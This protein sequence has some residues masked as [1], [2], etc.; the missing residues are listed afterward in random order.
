MADRTELMRV[1]RWAVPSAALW[2]ERKEAMMAVW[3]ADS[4]A[5]YWILESDV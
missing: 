5:D 4:R 1:A 2:V 3:K